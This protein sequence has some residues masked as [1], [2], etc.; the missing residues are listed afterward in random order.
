MAGDL[1]LYS[2]VMPISYSERARLTCPACLA[3]FDADVWI[4]VEAAERPDLA[5]A[6]R[7]G[8]LNTVA[9]PHCG[10]EGPAGAPLLFH[11]ASSRRVYFLSLIHI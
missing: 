3:P 4:L 10:H 6:L 11:D 9:C 5:Q 2:G 8:A 7:D 1:R